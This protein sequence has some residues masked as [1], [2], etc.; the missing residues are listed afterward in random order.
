M[1]SLPT[2]VL[3]LIG[4]FAVADKADLHPFGLVNKE[5]NDVGLVSAC[6]LVSRIL[7]T[8]R[9][10]LPT[11]VPPSQSQLNVAFDMIFHTVKALRSASAIELIGTA[12]IIWN[13]ALGILMYRRHGGAVWKPSS[14]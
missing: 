14:L 7:D 4:E 11:W 6:R 3:H 8:S 10:H 5:W 1:V 13:Q 12:M 2:A 9:C